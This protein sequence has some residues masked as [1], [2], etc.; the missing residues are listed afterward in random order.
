MSPN[1]ERR[2]IGDPVGVMAVGT[3]LHSYPCALYF[4]LLR[5]HRPLIFWS[6]CGCRFYPCSQNG[7]STGQNSFNLLVTFFGPSNTIVSLVNMYIILSYLLTFEMDTI[8]S[9]AGA[10]H[11]FEKNLLRAGAL[12]QWKPKGNPASKA[13]SMYCLI[14]PLLFEMELN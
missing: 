9:D 2:G 6:S 1:H 13:V 10:T 5:F 7:L 11:N 3:D 8:R 12:R 14:L 4:S